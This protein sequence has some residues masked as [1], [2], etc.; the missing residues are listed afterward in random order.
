MTATPWLTVKR[1]TAPLIVSFPHTGTD[2]SYVEGDVVSP[3]LARR[4][5]DWWIDQLYAFVA[6]MGATTVH[7]SISRTVIDV[8]RDPSGVSLYPGQATTELCPTTTFDGEPLYKPNR[9]PDAAEIAR[10]RALYFDPYHAAL[11]AEI[12]RLRAL[13][14]CVVLYDC[15]SIRSVI[16]RLFD[17]E[18]PVF[19][20]GTNDGKS[21]D[22]ALSDRVAALLNG[23]GQSYVVNGRFK[24]G[25]ITRTFGRP[26][27]GVHALQM[28]LACR[29]YMPEPSVAIS[30]ADWPTQFDP[31]YA[32]RTQ[33]T[34][35]Q[36]L[37][38]A[39]AWAK[40]PIA[41]DRA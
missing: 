25:S 10:R 27:D 1:G 36:I 33:T 21:A 11:G 14:R 23:C 19:N 3:W 29:G 41:G 8:N 35:Q 5:A 15:H 13:H 22:A 38:S 40:Q 7:T 12:K 2:I 34:L 4:D 32:A 17:G 6:G 16:P 24:G 28:E 9:A 18:L 20:F 31:A 37:L 39:L 26:A 30:P